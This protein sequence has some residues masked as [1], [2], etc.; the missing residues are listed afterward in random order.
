MKEV[1]RKMSGGERG[2]RKETSGKTVEASENTS[3]ANTSLIIKRAKKRERKR[4]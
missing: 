4:V 3:N 2:R 1:R